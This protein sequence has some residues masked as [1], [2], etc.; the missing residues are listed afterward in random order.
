MLCSILFVMTAWQKQET[1]ERIRQ[2][3]LKQFD[4]ILKGNL[5]DLMPI[6]A[7]PNRAMALYH[8]VKTS[9]QNIFTAD[10]LGSFRPFSDRPNIL[11]TTQIDRQ[12]C[13]Q[14]I[15]YCI[16]VKGKSVGQIYLS[17]LCSPNVEA[18]YWI[19]DSARRKGYV[20]EALKMVEAQVFEAGKQGVGL[21]I[22]PT[23]TA[24][25]ALAEKAGFVSYA[26]YG[27]SYIKTKEMWEKETE[28]QVIQRAI[29]QPLAGSQNQLEKS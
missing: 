7:M 12:K 9:P 14:N 5:V 3:D 6:T 25:K 26:K 19:V 15:Y 20:S 28:P 24:S 17:C 21:N 18:F 13:G 2:M 8:L 16:M 1:C 27:F 29:S 10:V 23:N 22:D 4:K 11:K